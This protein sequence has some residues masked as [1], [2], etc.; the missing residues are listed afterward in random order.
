MG[1]STYT[2]SFPVKP[3]I[4]RYVHTIGE[5][6]VKF[7]GKSMLCQ[8]I[9]A[10]IV[11]KK[12]L[13]LTQKQRSSFFNLRT[14]KLEMIIPVNYMSRVGI[15]VDHDGIILINRWLEEVFERALHQFIRDHTKSSGRYVGYKDAC[16][17][18]AELYNIILEED[19]TLDGLKK[20]EYR[21]RKKNK[22]FFTTLVPSL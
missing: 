6:P 12:S 4:K 11:N 5:A 18:F 14:E 1:T 22:I 2:V 8:I 10:F 21:F 7:N 13:C 3:Y 17:A 19:I 15:E 16:E 20:M 9:R